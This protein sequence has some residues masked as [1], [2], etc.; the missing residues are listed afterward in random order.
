[1]IFMDKIKTEK[2]DRSQWNIE[3]KQNQIHF[4][5]NTPLDCSE[6]KKKIYLT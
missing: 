2:K 3:R 5:F 1:M 6:I 4:C